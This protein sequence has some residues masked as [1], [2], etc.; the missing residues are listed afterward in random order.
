MPNKAGIQETLKLPNDTCDDPLNVVERVDFT[1]A[2]FSCCQ[3][4]PATIFATFAYPCAG[5]IIYKNSGGNF[6]EGCIHITCFPCLWPC[7]GT[8]KVKQVRNIKQILLWDILNFCF[9]PCLEF[10]RQYREADEFPLLKGNSKVI[11]RHS[12][13]GSSVEGS[14]IINVRAA[15]NVPSMDL[16]GTADPYVKFH[17]KSDQEV[18]FKSP[19]RENNF[20]PVWNCVR[21]FGKVTKDYDSVVVELHEFDRGKKDDFIG[22]VEIPI[23]DLSEE[24]RDFEVPLANQDKEKPCVIEISRVYLSQNVISKKRL[25]LI[26][27]GESKWNEAQEGLDPI[28]LM[29]FDH[30]LNKV[31]VA[32]ASSLNENWQSQ[33]FEEDERINSFLGAELICSSPLTRALMTAIIGL[34]DHPYLKEDKKMI[35]KPSLREVKKGGGLDTVGVAT[36]ADIK[37]RAMDSIRREMERD[38][39]S[40]YDCS[41]EDE[42]CNGIWW[43]SSVEYEK[44]DRLDFRTSDL[45]HYIHNN[46]HKNIILVGHSLFFRRLCKKFALKKHF[47][48]NEEFRERLGKEKM[49]NG[50]CLCI[51]V[52]WEGNSFFIHDAHFMFGTGFHGEKKASMGEIPLA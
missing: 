44:E 9:C 37:K 20:F 12:K 40:D 32:Q 17:L 28:G 33:R 29:D 45:L 5:G 38:D 30:P 13:I 23:K 36:G 27:H 39:I 18:L 22:E 21:D 35:L 52:L 2:I 46:E 16:N 24:I 19:Y 49:D 11:Y 7:I 6:W 14:L 26:R 4:I 15:R 31:G 25:F 41:I 50:A 3:D 47:V 42:E 1:H 51:D 43:T 34:Q 8:K 10:S 48:G